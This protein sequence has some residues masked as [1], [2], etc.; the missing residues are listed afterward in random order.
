V[1]LADFRRIRARIQPYVRTTPV[2]PT[3]ISNLFLKLENLQHTH[4]FKVRGAFAH[5]LELV[6]RGEKRQLLTVSAGNHGQAV[7]RAVSTFQL[8][9]MVVVPGNA[10]KA[11]IEAIR[12]YGVDLRIEGANYDEA[13]AWTLR[14]AENTNDYAF[15]SPYN[16]PLVVLGQGTVAFEI[17]EQGPDVAAIV[18]PVGGGG[19]IAGIGVAVKQL[20]PSVRVIGVQT[21]ASAAIYHSLRAGHMVQVPDLPS[22]ADGIAGNID[23]NSITFSL[24]QEHVDDVVLV[25]EE[26]I[27]ATM[28]HLLLKEKL[29]VEGGAAASAAAVMFNK[30][31]VGGKIVAVITGGN[32]DLSHGPCGA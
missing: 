31:D 14:L 2:V 19:L 25:S 23:L 17:L 4:A 28:D 13:E 8:S 11:K 21:E 24:I 27:K 10:P 20:R 30:V 26:Q 5:I 15:V 16:D 18:A 9:C 32:V 3:E 1:T 29:V 22:I 6:D 7:A 12:N